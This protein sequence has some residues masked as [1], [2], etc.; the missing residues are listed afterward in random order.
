MVLGCHFNIRFSSSENAQ[1]FRRLSMRVPL[2]ESP[3]GVIVDR[4]PRIARKG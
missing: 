3:E 4:C 2:G 1:E